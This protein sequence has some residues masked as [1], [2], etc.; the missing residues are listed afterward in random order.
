MKTL[1]TLKA[2]MLADPK[3]RAEYEALADEFEMAREL[4]SARTK[5]GMTQDDVAQKM[6]TTQSA[7]A[8]LESGK[9]MPSMRTVQ[10]YAKAIGARAVVRLESASKRTIR[11]A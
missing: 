10:R 2:A 11:R 9:R 7:V 6:G 3:T 5:A 8:R 1:K 4:I